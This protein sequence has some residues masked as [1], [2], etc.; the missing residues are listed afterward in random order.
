MPQTHPRQARTQTMTAT[1]PTLAQAL[2]D[3]LERQIRAGAYKAG[4]RLPSLRDLAQRH[5]YAKNTV[6]AAFDHLVLRGL[7]EPRR[8]AGYF[9]R[10][11]PP[12][13]AVERE[14][15]SLGRAMDIVWLMR[16]QLKSEPGTLSLGDGFPP[17]EWLSDVR[18][19]KYH[20]KVVRTGMGSLFRYGNR[21]GYEPLRKHLVRRLSD[22]GVGADTDQIVLTHG[23]NEAMDL[24]VR[25]FV[26][27]GATVFVDDPGYYPLFGK[28]KLAGAKIVGV[29]RQVDGPD[30]AALEALLAEHKPRLFFTQSTGHNP[31]GSDLSAAKAF[32]VLQLAQKHDL[33]LVEDDPMADFK[34]ASAPRLSSLDGLERTIYIG[35]FSK[36]FSAALRVGFVACDAELASDLADLKALVHVSS[37]EYCERTLDVILSD[38]HHQRH[39]NRLRS[40]LEDATALATERLRALD[41]QLFTRPTHSLYLWASLPGIGDSLTL[42]SQLLPHKVVL[43]PGRVFTVDHQAPSPWSRFNVGAVCDP[44]FVDLAAPALEAARKAGRM[45]SAS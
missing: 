37:S 1:R 26:P 31:T 12:T 6:V 11:L 16:A 30:L 15:G 3:S 7:V 28:L 4:E 14:T 5:D 36:S 25:Y 33:L 40:R 29:P 10:E 24:V 8:G 20:Q 35:S 32:K 9:V 41:A 27:P 18:L 23:A 44:R 38:S 2:A 22:Y 21:F 42:A 17:V 34:P 13:R 43:A 45:R 39:V 19:D